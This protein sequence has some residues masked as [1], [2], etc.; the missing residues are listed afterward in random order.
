M[1]I[2]IVLK[3]IIMIIMIIVVIIILLIIIIVIPYVLRYS[4]HFGGHCF[5]IIQYYYKTISLSAYPILYIVLLKIFNLSP[6]SV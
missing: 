6:H 2:K 3:L 4:H 5:C 1:I